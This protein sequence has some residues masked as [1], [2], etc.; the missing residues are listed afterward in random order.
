MNVYL[1]LL[2][3]L[4]VGFQF[5]YTTLFGAYSAYLFARTGHMM[6]P[7]IAHAFCNHMGFPDFTELG[8][9]QGV[10]RTFIASLFVLGLVLWCF[11]LNP[12]TDPS[13]F[14]NELF[15]KI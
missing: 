11:L 15:W 4:C 10:K 1:F 13:W 12:L 9:Y 6:A 2:S 3:N 8:A 7:F 14:A 5:F